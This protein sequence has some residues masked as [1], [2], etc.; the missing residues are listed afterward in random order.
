MFHV[1]HSVVSLLLAFLLALGCLS[2]ALAAEGETA[3]FSDVASDAWYAQAVELC[4]QKG[5]MAGTGEGVFSPDDVLSYNQCLT[6]ALRLYDLLHD[7]GVFEPAPEDWGKLTLTLADGTA[8]TGYSQSS[9]PLPGLEGAEFEFYWGVWRHTDYGCLC[10]SLE[11]APGLMDE[12]FAAWQ[13]AQQAGYDWGSAHE[14]VATVQVN[15]M[16]IPGT[17]NCWAPMGN[18]VL[19]FHPD[20]GDDSEGGAAIH[21]TLYANAPAPDA[22]WRDGAW[23][24]S[25]NEELSSQL[26]FRDKDGPAQRW[27]FAEALFSAAGELPA[28]RQVDIPDLDRD[29]DGS[30]STAVYAL[31]DAGVLTGTDAYGTFDGDGSLTRAQAAVMAARVLD[32]RQRVTTPPE[33]LPTGGYTLTYLMDGVPD[34][35]VNYPVCVLGG[36]E[37]NQSPGILLLD[38]TLLPWPEGGTPSYALAPCGD[39]VYFGV[40]DDTAEDP[41]DTRCGLMDRNGAFVVPMENGRGQATYAMEGGFF[42]EVTRPDGTTVWT[43]LDEEGRLIQEAEATDGDP[44]ELYP[45]KARSPFRGIEDCEGGCYL[46]ANGVPVSRKFDWAGHIT[47]DGQGFVGLGGKIYRIEFEQ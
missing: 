32:E 37:E 8:L 25:R 5:V 6:L 15:G 1:K 28:V 4:A 41:A 33:P 10:A 16:T 20:D 35:G 22:W 26:A 40:Y 13:D 42:S 39:Y 27:D 14:G 30:V 7:G 36:S 11:P 29:A 23:Y 9:E 19:S 12:D 47:A 21:D 24:L 34:C 43:L 17:V 45:P 3:A 38:G 46:D 18:W 31:Y 2:P 44:R